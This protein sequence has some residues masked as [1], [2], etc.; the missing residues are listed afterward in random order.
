MRTKS[1]SLSLSSVT[2]LKIKVR[3]TRKKLFLASLSVAESQVEAANAPLKQWL[4]SLGLAHLFPQVLAASSGLPNGLAGLTEDDLDHIGIPDANEKAILLAAIAESSDLPG[5]PTASSSSGVDE[6]TET[7]SP[8]PLPQRTHS[9][10]ALRKQAMGTRTASFSTNAELTEEAVESLGFRA[11]FD[12][13]EAYDK[14]LKKRRNIAM[15]ILHTEASYVS[16]LGKMRAFLAPLQLTA[17]RT[18]AESDPLLS[19]LLKL[20]FI[21]ALIVAP[22]VPA[23]VP[24]VSVPTQ[25]IENVPRI[26][27]DQYQILAAN[28]ADLVR[29][30]E[31]ILRSLRARIEDSWS[32]A[33][34]IGDVFLGKAALF[35]QYTK[36]IQQYE[37]AMALFES[38]SESDPVFAAYAEAFRSDPEQG[39]L[40]PFTAFLLQPVQR[41][42]RYPMLLASLVEK[43]K[44][45]HPDYP[46]LCSALV[47]VS[48]IAHFIDNQGKNWSRV[49]LIARHMVGFDT[50]AVPGRRLVIE[51]ALRV[52]Y[53]LAYSKRYCFLFSDG[54]FLIV[55]SKSRGKRLILQTSFNLAHLAHLA[56]S[57]H[58][59]SPDAPPPSPESIPDLASLAITRPLA[60]TG[61]T[62]SDGYAKFVFSDLATSTDW[63]LV[64][65]SA[66]LRREWLLNFQSVWRKHLKAAFLNLRHQQAPPSPGPSSQ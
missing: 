20:A 28:V 38:L 6:E 22:V 61:G 44:P 49:R 42:M 66:D 37:D 43:T 4:T 2:K 30:H 14:Y 47:Q 21:P 9:M 62:E 34:C 15:E 19:R 27:P 54:L 52:E 10:L 13:Q 33:T 51:G 45:S 36:F 55:K 31:S 1:G 16:A 8:P 18:A 65:N 11:E 41:I 64:A 32:V 58:Q 57:Q 40:L 3:R 35:L 48:E 60:G 46:A 59:P 39:G 24:A 29:I 17:M 12:S 5:T 63:I 56:V 26:R 50:L 7:E 25:S 23:L 53:M